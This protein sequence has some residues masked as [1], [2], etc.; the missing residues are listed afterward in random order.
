M[1]DF[2]KYH[3]F[4]QDKR[5]G[6]HNLEGTTDELRV[7]LSNTAPNVATHTVLADVS[8]LATANGYTAGGLDTGNN[9]TVSS[10]VLTVAATLGPLVWTASGA[11]ITA[12]YFILVN[13]TPAGDPLI[14]YWDRGNS[15]NVP[16]GQTISISFAGGNMFS[17]F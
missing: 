14:G 1:P 9:G 13:M 2:V 6:V 4:A 3:Q 5:D 15:T 17:D 11:G 7:V 16:A 12:R 8:E 10:G